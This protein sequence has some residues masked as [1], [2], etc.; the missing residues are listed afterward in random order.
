MPCPGIHLR[1]ETIPGRYPPNDT[2]G[3]RGFHSRSVARIPG[4]KG[5]TWGTLRFVPSVLLLGE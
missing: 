4:L 3:E 5:E 1:S 2:E